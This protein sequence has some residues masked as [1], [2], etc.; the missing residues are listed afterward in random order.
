MISGK[1]QRWR[2]TVSISI[3]RSLLCPVKNVWRENHRD[4]KIHSEPRCILGELFKQEVAR[5][6]SAF[7]WSQHWQ[8]PCRIVALS[9]D[10]IKLRSILSGKEMVKDWLVPTDPKEGCTGRVER[11]DTAS[12][13]TAAFSSVLSEVK[14][15]PNYYL[16]I[17]GGQKVFFK[18]KSRFTIFK[19]HLSSFYTFCDF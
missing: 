19:S 18:K 16:N 7:S 11:L 8:D 5:F 2:K 10:H 17:F 13:H 3:L 6:P 14:E 4:S 15:K 1:Y 9:A 12:T